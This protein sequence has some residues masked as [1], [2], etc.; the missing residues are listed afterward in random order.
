MFS[1]QN[2]AKPIFVNFDE[3]ED[4]ISEQPRDIGRSILISSL[5]LFFDV[6]F[7]QLG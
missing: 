3:A 6:A 4:E 5:R 7:E 2:D 1:T